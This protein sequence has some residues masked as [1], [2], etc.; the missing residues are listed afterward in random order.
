[1]YFDLASQAS[2]SCRVNHNNR[3]LF[4][5]LLEA[6]KDAAADRAKGAAF[7]NSLRIRTLMEESHLNSIAMNA[8]SNSKPP[9]SLEFACTMLEKIEHSPK[10]NSKKTNL[11]RRLLDAA[12]EVGDLY[13][14]VRLLIPQVRKRR[15]E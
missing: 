3:Q 12:R 7:Q 14:V 4:K 1:M 15:V 6:L 11:L 10:S 2:H 9:L 5:L 13:G 8:D